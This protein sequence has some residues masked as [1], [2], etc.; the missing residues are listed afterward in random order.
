MSDM[1]CPICQTVLDKAFI[2]DKIRGCPKCRNMGN[3][4]L[5][6]SLI[7]ERQH[8]TDCQ[9]LFIAAMAQKIDVETELDRTRKALETATKC[10][11]WIIDTY[12]T[13]QDQEADILGICE[14]TAERI[15]E[16]TKGGKDE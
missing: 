15:D 14:L 7:N 12:K 8:A 2:T 6:Q 4:E 10:I 16:I 1:K 9:D 11:N 5:W 3:I 13:G